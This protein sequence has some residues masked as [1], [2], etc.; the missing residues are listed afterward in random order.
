MSAHCACAMNFFVRVRPTYQ[1]MATA[2]KHSCL[3]AAAVSLMV[4]ATCMNQLYMHPSAPLHHLLPFQESII[5]RDLSSL[6]EGLSF[7]YMGL[8]H[9]R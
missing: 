9:R 6:L 8:L 4:T 1:N 2:Q 5:I 7:L 3:P